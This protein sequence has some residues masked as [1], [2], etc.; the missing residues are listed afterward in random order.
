MSQC[1][2]EIQGTL[3]WRVITKENR[4]L[5]CSLSYLE[6]IFF[7]ML[8]FPYSTIFLVSET[9]SFGFDGSNF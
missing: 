5:C 1:D 9:S 8:N 3:L 2:L 4:R 7:I 6:L